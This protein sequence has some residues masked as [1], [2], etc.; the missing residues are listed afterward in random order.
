MSKRDNGRP[1]KVTKIKDIIKMMMIVI[2]DYCNYLQFNYFVK[3]SL[4]KDTKDRRG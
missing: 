1:K 2:C 4:K 3:T